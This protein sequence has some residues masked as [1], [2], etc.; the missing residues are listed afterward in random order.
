MH[1]IWSPVSRWGCGHSAAAVCLRPMLLCVLYFAWTSTASKCG[2][3]QLTQ[4]LPP[5][6][7]LHRMHALTQ[8]MCFSVLSCTTQCVR[9]WARP[10]Q[11][12]AVERVAAAPSIGAVHAYHA[13]LPH[14][15]GTTHTCAWQYMC[16]PYTSHIFAT[17]SVSM[18]CALHTLH[19]NPFWGCRLSPSQQ[20]SHRSVAA[21]DWEGAA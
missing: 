17:I 3:W 7:P 4:F 5:P 21:G 16:W 10:C 20:I 12:L 1:C 6:T 9:L 19:G 8:G 15:L 18:P 14:V 13:S 11:V 2:A